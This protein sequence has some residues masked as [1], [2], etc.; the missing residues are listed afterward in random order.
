MTFLTFIIIGLCMGSGI[1]FSMYFGAKKYEKIKI[2]ASL[3]FCHSPKEYVEA[4]Q[5][6][7]LE[8]MEN[9]KLYYANPSN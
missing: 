8:I 9:A 7:I 1:L 5:E 6:C 3:K 4:K 2:E